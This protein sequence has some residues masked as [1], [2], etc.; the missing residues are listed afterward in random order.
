MAFSPLREGK[1]TPRRCQDIGRQGK[2]ARKVGPIRRG[3]HLPGGQEDIEAHR[4]DAL[5]VYNRP[6][7]HNAIECRQRRFPEL[8]DRAAP[9]R[10]GRCHI[11]P[12]KASEEDAGAVH[13]KD[14]L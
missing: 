3:G 14:R 6:W 8:A 13:T 10:D 2:K 4:G 7:R 11:R 1:S 12:D 5:R 9:A